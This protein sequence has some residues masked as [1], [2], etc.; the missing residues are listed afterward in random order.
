MT[1]YSNYCCFLRLEDQQKRGNKTDELSNQHKP[2]TR[3]NLTMLP[4]QMKFGLFALL[5]LRLQQRAK[6]GR[7]GIILAIISHLLHRI[8]FICGIA[9]LNR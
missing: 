5:E 1:Q 6:I 9:R 4:G 3:A 2:F 7:T 8:F